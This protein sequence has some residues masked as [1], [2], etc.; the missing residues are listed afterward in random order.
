VK[1]GFSR[2]QKLLNRRDFCAV[3]QEGKRFVG[4]RVIFFYLRKMSPYTRLGITITKKWGKAHDRNRFKRVAREAFRKIY[5]TLPK[6]LI[7]N[8]HP[9]EGY[10]DLTPEAIETELKNL[11]K[12]CGKTQRESTESSI[13]H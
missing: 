8:V 9:K 5:P 13:Y 11:T 2:F 10:Q 3:Y 4:K 6:G 12:L 1:L 7:I